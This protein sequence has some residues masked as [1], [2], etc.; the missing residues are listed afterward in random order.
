[1]KIYGSFVVKST[2]HNVLTS[3]YGVKRHIHI[4]AKSPIQI[5]EE[6]TKYTIV[7]TIIQYIV[8]L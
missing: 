6:N 1:M 5:Y 4:R 8:Q 7:Y 2:I 3:L